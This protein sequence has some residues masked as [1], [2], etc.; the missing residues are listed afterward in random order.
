MP[1]NSDAATT[2]RATEGR[3]AR[4]DAA[5]LTPPRDGADPTAPRKGAET[6]GRPGRRPH[7]GTRSARA[8]VPRPAERAEATPPHPAAP[9]SRLL[10]GLV[11]VV[12]L[13]ICWL[14]G[15]GPGPPGGGPARFPVTG[16]AAAVGRAPADPSHQAR[17]SAPHRRAPLSHGTAGQHD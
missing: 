4:P 2:P 9:A 12:L 11:G 17:T 1:T 13:L 3:P 5:H 10:A 15:G 14:C 6:A 16:D 7:G 8:R